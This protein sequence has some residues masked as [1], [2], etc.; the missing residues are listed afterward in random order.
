MNEGEILS[1]TYEIREQIGSGS[2]G[3]IYRAYHKRL[4]KDVV[5]KKINQS[6]E[7]NEDEKEILKNLKHSYLPQVYDFLDVEDGVFTI[8]DYIPGES[9]EKLLKEK[10]KFPQ[11]KVV[12][13]ARQLCEVV[14]YLH[15]QKPP[16]I[17]GDIKPASIML[18]PEDNICLI[19]FNI[20]GVLDGKSMET[21]GYTPGYAPPEQMASFQKAVSMQGSGRQKAD[22]TFG[23][24]E[25]GK[26]PGTEA[27]AKLPDI[28]EKTELLG[29]DEKTELLDAN[30]RTELPGTDERRSLPEGNAVAE[31]SDAGREADAR[32]ACYV[33]ARSDVYSMGATLYHFLTGVRPGSEPE[34]IVK[35]SEIDSSIGESISLI[36][37]KS[38][39]REPRRR[40]Q[41]A[42]SMLKAF[43]KIHKYDFR[44]KKMVL[45][46]E[47]IFLVTAA[48]I[49]AGILLAFLGK[50][51]LAREK[52]E[53]YGQAVALLSDVRIDGAEEQMEEAYNAAREIKPQRLEA[54]FQKALYYY[55]EKKYEEGIYFIEDIILPE[56]AFSDQELLTDVYFLLGNCQFETEQYEEAVISYRAAISRD[57]SRPEFYRDYVI[58]LVRDE[59]ISNAEEAL[60][61][62]GEKGISSVDL[63]LINGE[64]KKAKGDYKGAEQ[65]LKQCVNE[66]ENDEIRMRAYILCDMVYREQYGEFREKETACIWLQKSM[67][68]LEEARTRVGLD[69]QLLIYE[70]LAQ[71]YID[72]Q[73]LTGEEDYG[74]N[75]ISIL[76]EVIGRGWGTYLTYNNI[77][78]MYQ[79]MG[80]FPQAQEILEKMIELDTGNYNTY[81]RLA[82]LEA[83]RQNQSQISERKYGDFVQYYE[84]T[85]ELYEVSGAGTDVEIQLLDN[86]YHQI[87][88]GGWLK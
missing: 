26:L 8:I 25:K 79:K 19:D 69:N 27:A 87:A 13:Y 65:D 68:L 67:G 4:Q 53:A 45:Q 46:Q 6:S 32:H 28:D 34:R 86:L 14:D 81:K 58:S 72:L 33:D 48:G 22:R 7:R 84:K 42:E 55:E 60:R 35:P 54:Y 21:M 71:T 39:V 74:E 73:E 61:Q 57:D 78:I 17:H 36:L 3:T 66:A 76:R 16:I 83:E 75:A 50:G 37:M 43:Q 85:K 77:A 82:F 80:K 29:T 59:K 41:T 24:F 38:L 63:L 52:E 15:K 11:K 1:S 51:Q 23:D 40:F 2:G 88:E 49:G 62:A 70:R 20:S 31:Q 5:L 30:E 56:D 10:G 44:Y 18:T 64:M 47:L 9:F 12:K